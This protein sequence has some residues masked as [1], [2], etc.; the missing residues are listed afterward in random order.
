M[1]GSI[2]EGLFWV[3]IRPSRQAES[4]QLQSFEKAVE[5]AL[6]CPHGPCS[7]EPCYRPGD[8]VRRTVA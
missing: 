7:Q 2:R 4:G 3:E 6:C 8:A 1:K 5:L